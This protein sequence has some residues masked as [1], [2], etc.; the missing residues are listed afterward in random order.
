MDENRN[1]LI[2]VIV[3]VYNVEEYLKKCIDSIINQTYLKLEIILVDDGSTDNSGII[4]DS[5]EEKD[6][7]IIVIH[8][9]NGGLSDARNK[10]LDVARGKYITFVDSDDYIEKNYVEFLYN[11]IIEKDVSIVAGSNCREYPEKTIN[12]GTGVNIFLT[13]K[14]ALEK[15]LYE[16]D[17]DTSA[18]GKLYKKDL[19]DD[20]RF[21]K[22]RIYEDM[23]TTYKVIDKVS[24]VYLS[25]YPIYHY[26]VRST[27]L[28]NKNS[29][30]K[31]EDFILS[32]KE[33][34]DYILNKYPDLENAV[35]RR[36]IKSYIYILLTIVYYEKRPT[37]EYYTIKKYIKRNRK[38]VL[39]NKKISKKDRLYIYVS[40]MGFYGLKIF[41]KTY[42]FVT[43]RDKLFD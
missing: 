34:G 24:K 25:S 33:M 35:M 30:K 9:E 28:S 12:A 22:G 3:P 8:K 6:K 18:W 21:P 19:F 42:K 36:T 43:K 4:C 20:V 37:E 41:W 13:A 23:A 38:D 7:R 14:E 11:L 40:Y 39:K 5:Y 2:S 17:F 16:D 10:G 15:M 31:N 1:D 26:I 27:S 32:T 29:K